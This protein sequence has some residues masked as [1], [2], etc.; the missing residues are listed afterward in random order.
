MDIGIGIPNVVPGTDGRTIVEWSRRA[1]A[2]GF[3]GLATI[4]R[5]AYPS[6]DSLVTL[7]AAAAVTERVRLVTNVL[8]GPTRNPVLLAKETASLDRISGGRFV[9]GVGVGMRPDDYVASGQDFATRGKR[10]DQD[11]EIIHRAW[12]GELVNGALKPIG[13]SPTNGDRVPILV[14]GMSDAAIQRTVRWGVGWTVGG[15]PADQAGP[16]ADRVRQAWKEAGKPGEPRIVGLTYFGLRADAL[17]LA[18]AYLGDYYGDF[19]KQ[20]AQFIPKSPEALKEAVK[21]YQDFRFDE[22]FLVPTVAD[23]EEIDRAATAVL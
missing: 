9:L 21:T 23:L 5:V 18:T 12:K 11:L 10:W 19:G 15:A 6:Y 13:P 8:L 1:E 22:L 20:I 2:H 7:A 4:D 17:D 16:F 14:G 3:S